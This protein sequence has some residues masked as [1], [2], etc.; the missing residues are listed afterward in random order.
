MRVNRV[1]LVNYRNYE[2]REVSFCEGVNVVM[3]ANAQGKTNL[4]ESVILSCIGRSPRTPRDKE[5]IRHGADS[6]YVRIDGD[7]RVGRV[8]VETVL[9]PHENKRIRINGLPIRRIG[10]LMGNLNAVFFSPDELRIV[11]AGPGDRR[12]FLDIDISQMSK[13]FFYEL[14]RYNHVLY[15]RNKLLKSGRA[16]ED[17]LAVWDIQLAE[18]GARIIRQRKEFVRRLAVFCREAHTFLTDGAESLEIAYEGFDGD[19]ED[20]LKDA[21]L[22]AL[23]GA[24]ER[25]NKLGFTTQGLHKDDLIITV[26]GT[27]MRAYGSQGQQRTVAL[28]LKLA[29]LEIFADVLGEY[30][31]LILDDVMSELDPSRQRKLLERIRSVQTLITCTHLEIPIGGAHILHVE[32]GRITD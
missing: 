30:P 8:T 10:E 12:R 7:R 17:M 16:T 4:V 22:A 15:Q 24:R 25:D 11:K 23:A 19:T 1:K 27:D 21:F 29:E 32:N 28:S 2:N 6:A 13:R 26:D 18:T 31:V 3:G 5:L 14:N 9:S 20:E